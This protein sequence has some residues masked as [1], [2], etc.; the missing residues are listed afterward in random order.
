MQYSAKTGAD[1][2]LHEKTLRTHF[3]EFSCS[4]FSLFGIAGFEI[5]V[6]LAP[7]LLVSLGDVGGRE[8]HRTRKFE[9]RY[10]NQIDHVERNFEDINQT[11]VTLVPVFVKHRIRILMKHIIRIIEFEN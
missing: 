1:E 9:G 8:I 3:F 11:L 7:F 6:N 2:P 5:D 4:W 10:K